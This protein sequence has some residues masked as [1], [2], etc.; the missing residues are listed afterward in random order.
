VTGKIVTQKN[1][2]ESHYFPQAQSDI[3]FN[4]GHSKFDNAAKDLAPQKIPHCSS[5]SANS[6]FN[7][8]IFRPRN[9]KP[10][11][12][13]IIKSPNFRRRPPWFGNLIPRSERPRSLPAEWEAR[14]AHR[15]IAR[16]HAYRAPLPASIKQPYF[17][18]ELAVLNVLSIMQREA[19][20]KPFAA[21]QD[22]VRRRAHISVSTVYRTMKKAV[23]LGDMWLE[24]LR[25][26]ASR[27]S[28][29]RIVRFIGQAY[30]AVMNAG[31]VK[32]RPAPD[33]LQTTAANVTRRQY[34]NEEAHIEQAYKNKE[35]ETIPASAP[36]L[37]EIARARSG[38]LNAQWHAA[39]EA[40]RG[41][42][43]AQTCRRSI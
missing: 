20:G 26:D 32:H 10:R 11:F 6:G 17:P 9:D 1:S 25:R 30:E 29:P 41:Q 28:L 2:T 33:L 7:S 34:V 42:K 35:L 23:K 5:Q 36:T 40:R 27:R 37:A 16:A 12:P 21:H 43:E 14:Q 19:G 3:F 4:S 31:Q 13:Q 38:L 22:E 15:Q 24:P 8:G 39:K 18:D